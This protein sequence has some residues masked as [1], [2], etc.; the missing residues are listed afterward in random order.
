MPKDT[1]LIFT[2]FGLPIAQPRQRHRI[3]QSNGR[4]YA[5][6]Y[7]PTRHPVNAFKAAV[8]ARFAEE[9]YEVAVLHRPAKVKLL[10]HFPRPKR[11]CGPKLAAL[12]HRHVSKP[13][14]ENVAKAVLDALTGICWR[15]DSQVWS[16][17]IEKWYA[18]VGEPASCTIGI[19][20]EVDDG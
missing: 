4:S 3:I 2:V 12:P 20:W 11:L 9:R 16:L 1:G 7:T 14:A 6:N 13:D 19:W 17:E 15:D 18:G 5:M 8:Q 10:C